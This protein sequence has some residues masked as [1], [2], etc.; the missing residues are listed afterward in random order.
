MSTITCT[1]YIGSAKS[2]EVLIAVNEKLYLYKSENCRIS[3]LIDEEGEDNDGANDECTRLHVSAVLRNHAILNLLLP[4][5]VVSSIG[6]ERDILRMLVTLLS[7]IDADLAFSFSVARSDVLRSCTALLRNL[8][9]HMIVSLEAIPSGR[10]ERSRIAHVGFLLRLL[11][12]CGISL[13]LT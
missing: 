2:K 8:M 10:T 6:K 12:T 13:F 9:T 1:C 11:D 7:V 5:L 4:A 3:E